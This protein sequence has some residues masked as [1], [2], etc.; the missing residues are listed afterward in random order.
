MRLRAVGG[1]VAGVIAVL[2][3]TAVTAA[4][5]PLGMLFPTFREILA[6]MIPVGGGGR[7]VQIG[8]VVLAVA[9]GAALS[10]MTER[11]FV[12]SAILADAAIGIVAA[13]WVFLLARGVTPLPSGPAGDD[14]I[15]LE[16]AAIFA[17]GYLTIAIGSVLPLSLVRAWSVGA[18]AGRARSV[19]HV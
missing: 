15:A 9:L 18:A 3:I 6:L 7:V 4:S 16:K 12:T 19:G 1:L 5:S 8:L 2:T 11:S 17:A 14:A 10:P 13:V